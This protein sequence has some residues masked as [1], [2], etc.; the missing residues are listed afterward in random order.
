MALSRVQTLLTRVANVSLSLRSIV[1][2]EVSVQAQHEGQ[3]EI[4]GPDIDIS[5]KAAEVMTPALHEL[6][7]NAL[8]YG[9]LSVP[10]GKVTVRWQIV[11]RRET[12]WLSLDW[13]EC[14]QPTAE[15]EKPRRQGFGSEL[16]EG[17]IP[18]ELKG[19]GRLVIEPDGARCHFEFPLKGA[20]SILET[21]AP[22]RATVFGGTLDMTGEFDQP[23]NTCRR[24]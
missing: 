2:D 3:Y 13:T 1:V 10:D 21:S 5:P 8:K 11:D 20:P 19:R 16:I 23:P 7:T 24:G 6:S 9:A 12:P 22:Q 14:G 18:Y 17:R 4:E 15:P